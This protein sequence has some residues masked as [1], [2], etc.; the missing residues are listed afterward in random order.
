[1]IEMKLFII[2]LLLANTRAQLSSCTC[3]C[4]VNLVAGESCTPISLPS[5]AVQICTLESCLAQCRATYSQCRGNSP[6][7]HISTVPQCVSTTTTTGITNGPAYN[8]RC[9]CCNTGST[10][11]TPVYIGNAYSYSCQAGSCSI[12][13][14]QRYPSQC[15][16]DHTGL[17][18]GTC[19]NLVTTTISPWLGNLCKCICCSTNSNCPSPTVG[20]TSASSCSVDSCTQACRNQYP[21]SCLLSSG[22]SQTTGTCL[23]ATGGRT[24]CNCECRGTNGILT[25]RINNNDDCT[26]CLSNCQQNSPCTNTNQVLVQSCSTN[27]NNSKTILLPM[28]SLLLI[29]IFTFFILI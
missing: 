6:A 13:C 4:C 20:V 2:V 12:S 25:Y 7:D 28:N 1:M 3:S 29:S 19:T 9:D 10:S 26:T 24:N 17:T 5:V 14:Q 22:T 27:P 23:S 21:A 8:C 11:C 15:R 18:Q 16:A